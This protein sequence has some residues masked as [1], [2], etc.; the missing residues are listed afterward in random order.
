MHEAR[1]LRR[2]VQPR[3]PHRL[4]GGEGNAAR[5]WDAA[6]GQPL[7]PVLVHHGFVDAV[8]FSPDGRTALTG[9][10]DGAA[11]FWEVPLPVAGEVEQILRW[12]EVLTGVQWDRVDDPTREASWSTGAA[13]DEVAGVIRGLDAPAW[14]RL[15]QE[16]QEERRPRDQHSGPRSSPS[17]SGLW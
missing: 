11:R 16:L 12:V 17:A 8:A 6:T 7:G 14:H 13:D 4:T 15:R 10:E 5:V 3:R 9:S 1:S 2:G